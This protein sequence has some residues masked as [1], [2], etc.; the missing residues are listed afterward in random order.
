[1]ISHLTLSR[2]V[3]A[4]SLLLL[5]VGCSKSADP[6][7]PAPAPSPEPAKTDTM[8]TENNTTSYQSV[9]QRVSYGVGHNMASSIMRQGGLDVD[10]DAFVAGFKRG[11]AGEGPEIAEADLQAAICD[12]GLEGEP[13]VSKDVKN[14]TTI[15]LKSTSGKGV[16]KKGGA[17]VPCLPSF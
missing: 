17:G 13:L 3:L 4:T 1:M 14:V 8:S 16:T 7:E 11:L 15:F 2:G 12:A 9:D 5:A 6:V 10:L